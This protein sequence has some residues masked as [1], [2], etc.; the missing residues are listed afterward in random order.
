MG[1]LWVHGMA[2]S[3]NENGEEVELLESVLRS[4]GRR[5]FQRNNI[6]PTGKYKKELVALLDDSLN[7]MV[8]LLLDDM[9]LIQEGENCSD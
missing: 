4:D 5:F 7:I 6:F 9:L 1:N 3:E 2:C 8:L